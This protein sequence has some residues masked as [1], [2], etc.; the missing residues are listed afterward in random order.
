MLGAVKGRALTR[1]PQAVSSLD[2]SCAPWP[3]QPV[4][5]KGVPTD[6]TPPP[7]G[8]TKGCYEGVP[9]TV[10]GWP[11]APTRRIGNR[12]GDGLRAHGFRNEVGVL[13]QT[14]AGALD[15]HDDGVVKK[16]VEQRGRDD[17]IAKNLA[18]FGKAAIRSQN[19][20]ALLVAGVD[21]LEEQVAGAGADG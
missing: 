18:P 17:G 3:L 12:T 8:R 1:P 15:M 5:T 4:G 7:A 6:S 14:V 19:H 2:R 9:V 16:S 11:S 21:Q 10:F 20:R 13:A